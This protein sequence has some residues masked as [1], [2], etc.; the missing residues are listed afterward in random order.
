[1]LGRL[2]AFQ[3]WVET[4]GDD[5]DEEIC[6]ANFDLRFSMEDFDEDTHEERDEE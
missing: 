5:E 6:W 4:D 3:R 1:V 2:H